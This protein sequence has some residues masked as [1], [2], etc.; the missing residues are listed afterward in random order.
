MISQLKDNEGS[1]ETEW[2]KRIEAEVF[3]Q[4]KKAHEHL[5]GRNDEPPSDVVSQKLRS[6][7]STTSSRIEA[8]KSAERAKLELESLQRKK[9]IEL[10]REKERNRLEEEKLRLQHEQEQRKR[11]IEQEERE[12]IMQ[13]EARLEFEEAWAKHYA[14]QMELHVEEQLESH[15]S[16]TSVR[17]EVASPVIVQAAPVIVQAAPQPKGGNSER[18]KSVSPSISGAAPRQRN[19]VHHEPTPIP[20]QDTT[21]NDGI[22]VKL[23]EAILKTRDP[24]IKKFDGNPSKY[25]AFRAAFKKLE[26]E[27]HYTQ[28]EL[29]DL[30]LTHTIGKA[31]T[32]LR[33]I[34]PGGGRYDKAWDILK[35]RFGESTQIMQTYDDELRKFAV[36]S[37]KNVEQLR[38]LAETISSLVSAFESLG[39]EAELES[40]YHVREA[41]RKL[42][43]SLKLAWARHEGEELKRNTLAYFRSWLEKQA[44][45]W[46]RAFADPLQEKNQRDTKPAFRRSNY[47]TDVHPSERP[48]PFHERARHPLEQ[49]RMF[50]A[51]N[52]KEK[53]KIVRD[54]GLCLNCFGKYIRRQCKERLKC[55]VNNCQQNHHH[56]L[57]GVGGLF[58]RNEEKPPGAGARVPGAGT[59]PDEGKKPPE[60]PET[61]NP[62]SNGVFTGRVA[63]SQQRIVHQIVPVVL[64]G[65]KGSKPGNKRPV[66]VIDRH[67][68]AICSVL[69]GTNL[70]VSVTLSGT[71]FFRLN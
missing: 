33:G 13:T 3:C 35:E 26:Q 19:E 65:P 1:L 4:V 9:E 53:E 23:A 5:M 27:K 63:A 30:L 54:K 2:F 46:E 16:H 6:I 44:K 69:T 40:S 67:K 22:L 41:V 56:L 29:L 17:N 34:L 61:V 14:A 52:S 12:L 21:P 45:T 49:C 38:S 24:H 57:H 28:D 11:S 59:K 71:N 32:A 47:R 8:R 37:E 60:V 18:N 20:A 43:P 51:L 15:A 7:R 42:P 70:I 66:T 50:K 55:G 10:Q 48:C 58:R 64:Y 31:E 25:A 68:Y 39:K 36:V 62:S